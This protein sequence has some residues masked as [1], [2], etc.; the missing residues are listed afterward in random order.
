[1]SSLGNDVKITNNS[2]LGERENRPSQNWSA[3]PATQD[4][5]MNGFALGNAIGI[6][7]DNIDVSTD[8]RIAG[9]LDVSGTTNILNANISNDLDVGNNLDVS[10][11]TNAVDINASNISATGTI[12]FNKLVQG[13]DDSGLS[14]VALELE[15]S[16]NNGDVKRFTIGKN[17][18]N[19][20]DNFIFA[21]EYSSTQANRE[22]RLG[23]YNFPAMK[24]QT[25]QTLFEGLP[26]QVNDAVGVTGVT[27]VTNTTNSTSETNGALVISGGAGIAKDAFIGETLTSGSALSSTGD[28]YPLEVKNSQG[29]RGPS[30]FST[31]CGIKFYSTLDNITGNEDVAEI[32][33]SDRNGSDN[34]RNAVLQFRVRDNTAGLT[35]NIPC[36]MYN[37]K[38]DIPI[39]T[40]SNSPTTG[41]LTVAG[42][43]G[44][45]GDL[46]CASD[47]AFTGRVGANRFYYGVQ[48]RSV[49]SDFTLTDSSPQVQTC[50]LI[51]S[52]NTYK[53]LLPNTTGLQPGSSWKISY[54]AGATNQLD[55]RDNAD[56]TTFISLT[57][58][59]DT[60]EL[61]WDGTANWLVF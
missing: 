25:T 51:G 34:A 7:T 35:T 13:A 17:S 44:L 29:S 30:G 19:P 26:V 10:G 57:T 21:Y 11:T 38:V 39:T 5:D 33:A 18:T 24:F 50:T 20:G 45:S 14:G 59:G 55:I 47:G 31:G 12:S 48:I 36:I 49:S 52:G 27:S 46:N 23:L 1:M 4:V 8:V 32:V 6:A 58:V 37:D 53:C 9:N 3:Y 56:T 40:A 15:S 16:M 22:C 28:V 2:S 54:T 61:I 42:G 41:A 43:M 60:T